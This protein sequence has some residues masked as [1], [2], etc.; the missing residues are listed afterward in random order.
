MWLNYIYLAMPKVY[1][2][3][4]FGIKLIILKDDTY[5]N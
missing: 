3:E 5:E 4:V 2:R 1:S